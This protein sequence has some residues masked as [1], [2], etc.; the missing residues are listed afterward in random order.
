MKNGLIKIDDFGLDLVQLIKEIGIVIDYTE[1]SKYEA[2]RKDITTLDI[3]SAPIYLRDFNEA[4]DH[5]SNLLA[6]LE[7]ALSESIIEMDSQEA[8]A[9]MERAPI[10]FKENDILGGGIKDSATLRETYLKLDPFYKVA[11][12]KVNALKALYKFLEKKM[13]AFE[14]DYY[15]VKQIHDKMSDAPSSHTGYHGMSSGGRLGDATND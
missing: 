13:K 2:Q 8:K 9:K 1:I 15:S 12:Q 5:V 7:L 6:K 4:C 14:R 3:F 10:Y 11:R